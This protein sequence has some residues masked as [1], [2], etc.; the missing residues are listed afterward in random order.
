MCTYFNAEKSRD[1]RLNNQYRWDGALKARHCVFSW[2]FVFVY[3]RTMHVSIFYILVY[4]ELKFTRLPS[5]SRLETILPFIQYIAWHYLA[6]TGLCPWWI[7]SS[8][9]FFKAIPSGWNSPMEYRAWLSFVVG[10]LVGF[11]V[12]Q[13]SRY[14]FLRSALPTTS[15]CMFFLIFSLFCLFLQLFD[16]EPVHLFAGCFR[17]CPRFWRKSATERQIFV[18]GAG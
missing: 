6:A 16:S 7:L 10:C 15:S 11:F 2:L 13:A 14:P 1:V 5:R 18:I 12:H 3:G 4:L 9:F 17:D 8:F